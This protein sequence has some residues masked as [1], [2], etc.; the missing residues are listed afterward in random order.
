M[1]IK[2]KIITIYGD[3]GSG[4]TMLAMFFAAYFFVCNNTRIF[5]NVNFFHKNKKFWKKI[6]NLKDIEK[7]S[8][9]DVK[10]LVILDEG[11]LNIN[12]RRS[13][14]NDNLEFAKLGMLGRKKNI[15][16]VIIAQL[17]YSLDKYFRDLS[18]AS[19][20][21]SSFFLK[22]DYLFFEAK[23][24][25]KDFFV[26]KK[27]FDLFFLLTNTNFSYDSL[28][29]SI[30]YTKAKK[31]KKEIKKE[32]KKQTEKEIIKKTFDFF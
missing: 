32:I 25:K 14:S 18:F 28:E 7:I 19:L 22:K 29:D 13:M 10:G 5:S 31:N 24:F 8:Y 12:S 21:M 2:N 9:N 30:L 4:K 26:W 20:Y 16:I 3:P 27:E 23:I 17:D 1:I 6:E 15:D 11:W